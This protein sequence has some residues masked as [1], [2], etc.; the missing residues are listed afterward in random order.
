MKAVFVTSTLLALTL[1]AV[2]PS[3]YAPYEDKKVFTVKTTT[4]NHEK[5]A[6]IVKDLGLTAWDLPEIA[7]STA[8]I[9][10]APRQLAAF[11]KATK[12][13][14]I[15]LLYA[16]LAGALAAERV[17]LERY[18]SSNLRTW[19]MSYHSPA[20]HLTFL[21]DLQSQFSQNSKI[22]DVGPSYERRTIKAIH[23]F[24]DNSKHKKPPILFLGTIHAREWISTMV[25]EYIAWML[26]KSKDEAKIKRLLDQY[27]FYIVPVANPDGFAYTQEDFTSSMDFPPRFWRKNRQPTGNPK[28]IGT[29][30][31]RNYPWHW[32][33]GRSSKDPCSDN[34]QGQ[35]QG[36]APEIQSVSQF[37]DRISV[38]GKGKMFVD[39]H[40]FGGMFM[41]PYGYNCTKKP[42]N[43]EQQMKFATKFAEVVKATHGEIYDAGPMCSVLYEAGG[44]SSDWAYG[45]KNFEYSFIAELRPTRKRLGA[46][47]Q[48]FLLPPQQIIP[49]GEETW[50][51]IL[52]GM[53]MM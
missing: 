6:I 46:V 32:G 24:G 38:N 27:D 13:M 8:S 20:E 50:A 17:V 51:G 41:T 33:K 36:Y 14:D 25:V 34:Y 2:A 44:A 37:V 29:D 21:T 3:Q 7:G 39:T 19:F 35:A 18:Q 16:S 42:S 22:V 15:R 9:A 40:S 28:C 12:G 47:P 26:L 52:A 5:L 4:S 10:V 49:T 45:A 23:I 31:N 48:G 11:Q 53:S 43:H 30:L 1:A